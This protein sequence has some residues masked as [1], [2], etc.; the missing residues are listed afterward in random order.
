MLA[1]DLFCMTLSFI[2]FHLPDVK[3][4]S[5]FS[6]KGALQLKIQNKHRNRRLT[7]D[8]FIFCCSWKNMEESERRGRSGKGN[9]RNVIMCDLPRQRSPTQNHQK[10]PRREFYGRWSCLGPQKG[11]RMIRSQGPHITCLTCK[12][13]LVNEWVQFP[14]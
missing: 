10:V 8:V 7:S 1:P 14:L 6:F 3:F 4:Q 9:A 13:N 5:L 12:V 11:W 2:Y